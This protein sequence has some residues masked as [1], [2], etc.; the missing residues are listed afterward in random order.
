MGQTDSAKPLSGHP[1]LKL[2]MV[3]GREIPF[4]KE[5]FFRHAEDWSE[6]AAVALAHESGL[7]EMSDAHWRI[8]RF[9]RD[10][11]FDRGRAPMNRDL[12]AG[13]GLSLL[14]LENLFPGGIR[15]GAR[16]LAGLPNPRT[17]TG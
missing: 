2:R 3:A 16:R 5:G 4:D 9:M 1:N 12:K 13:T 8:L 10:F 17:C 15:Q 7:N 6:D 14:E 11:Y